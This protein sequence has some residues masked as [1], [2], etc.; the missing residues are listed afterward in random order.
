MIK[1]W[2][3]SRMIR[4]NR[5]AD[6]IAMPNKDITASDIGSAIE[7]MTKVRNTAT[8]TVVKHKV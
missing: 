6:S 7:S 5:V 3:D 4:D 1:L 8:N 2:K